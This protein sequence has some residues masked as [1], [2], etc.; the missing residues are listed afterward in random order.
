MY[1]VKYRCSMETWLFDTFIAPSQEKVCPLQQPRGGDLIEFGKLNDFL[2]CLRFRIWDLSEL[3]I[4][5]FE[6]L[7]CVCQMNEFAYFSWNID[8][9]MHIHL[10]TQ[11]TLHGPGHPPTRL[12]ARPRDNNGLHGQIWATFLLFGKSPC[13][14]IWKVC[15]FLCCGRPPRQEIAFKYILD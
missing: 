9:R 13:P 8:I 4:L 2:I 14:N 11:S 7:G 15:D 5:P 1:I 10:Q 6:H 3:Q 12:P